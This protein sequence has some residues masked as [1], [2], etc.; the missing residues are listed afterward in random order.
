[1]QSI[2]HAKGAWAQ[3]L[4]T[5][6]KGILFA[7]F[8]KLLI[9]LIVVIPGITMFVLHQQ[10]VFQQEMTDVNGVDQARSCISYTNESLPAGLKGLA[11]AAL[12]AAIVASLAGKANSISTIFA[13]D[14]YKKYFNKK[15]S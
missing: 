15:A 14:F 12:T 8:L 10:G 7:A 6:R 11:F 4:P 2:H 5:A 1:M 3:V 13:L 9:P